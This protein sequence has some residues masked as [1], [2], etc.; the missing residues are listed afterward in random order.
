MIL[1][2]IALVSWPA[3]VFLRLITVSCARD[4]TVPRYAT[5]FWA[6]CT[7]VA[8]IVGVLSSIITVI[9]W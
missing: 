8:F 9:L 4:I 3:Y 6:V 7:L 2:K 5:N 1:L